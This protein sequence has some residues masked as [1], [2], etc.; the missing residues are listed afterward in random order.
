MLT[1]KHYITG[2]WVETDGRF[3]SQPVKGAAHEFC[4]GTP[5]LVE[6]AV[7]AAERA[8]EAYAATSRDTRANFLTMIADRIGQHIFLH[9]HVESTTNCCMCPFDIVFAT[10]Y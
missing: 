10:L 2:E 3:L 4:V 9:Q 6:K 8:F 5:A 1:G 7:I